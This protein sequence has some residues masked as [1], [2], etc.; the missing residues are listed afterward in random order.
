[1]CLV[2]ACSIDIYTVCRSDSADVVLEASDVN[3]HSP[4]FTQREYY[5]AVNESDLVNTR[6][7]Q[8]SAT[9]DDLGRQQAAMSSVY[10]LNMVI[11]FNVCQNILGQLKF[12]H[13]PF[14]Y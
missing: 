3:D 13:Y 8:L 6:F 9:D 2:F 11:L 1:M 10:L 7:L 4:V 14:D 12:L 5:V